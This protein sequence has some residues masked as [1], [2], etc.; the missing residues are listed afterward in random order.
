M[1]KGDK[2]RQKGG[3]PPK[4]WFSYTKNKENYDGYKKEIK[5]DVNKSWPEYKNGCF[6]CRDYYNNK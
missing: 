2:P 5:T 1:A 3:T 6:V 4:K